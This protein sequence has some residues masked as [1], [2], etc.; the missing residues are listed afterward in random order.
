MAIYFPFRLWLAYQILD[1]NHLGKLSVLFKKKIQEW[2]IYLDA[3][4]DSGHL[5]G[6]PFI[7]KEKV[8]DQ[9][10]E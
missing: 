9:G 3:E 8:K 2:T 5:N 4:I 1:L 6:Q 10:I 7:I